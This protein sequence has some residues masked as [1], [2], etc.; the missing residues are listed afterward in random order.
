MLPFCIPFRFKNKSACQLQFLETI[1]N[2]EFVK[3][4]YERFR[5]ALQNMN[6]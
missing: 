6:C 3:N 1:T 2:I 5:N 4:I